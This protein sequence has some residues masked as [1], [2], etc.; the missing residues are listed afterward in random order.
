MKDTPKNA[1]E[2]QPGLAF[3]SVCG[4]VAG[5]ILLTIFAGPALT[6]TSKTAEQLFTPEHYISAVLG[7]EE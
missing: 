5:L 1:P 2:P 4:L 6:Y 3:T 7:G